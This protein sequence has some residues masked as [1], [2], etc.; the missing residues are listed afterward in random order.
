MEE[1]TMTMTTLTPAPS[2]NANI[3]N[4]LSVARK[5]VDDDK[6]KGIAGDQLTSDQKALNAAV[7]DLFK[8]DIKAAATKV[9][10]GVID[11]ALNRKVEEEITKAGYVHLSEKPMNGFV[12]E[13]WSDPIFGHMYVGSYN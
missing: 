9:K 5:K 2:S 1:S 3:N 8:D 12:Q 4:A 13:Q 10:G 11:S 6:Q 7:C